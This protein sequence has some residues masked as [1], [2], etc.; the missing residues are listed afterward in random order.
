MFDNVQFSSKGETFL[1]KIFLLALLNILLSKYKFINSTSDFVWL[2]CGII[3]IWFGFWMHVT[4]KLYEKNLRK[5]ATTSK[6]AETPE[7]REE[8][9]RNKQV[10]LD[11]AFRGIEID[12]R[13]S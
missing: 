3:L 5:F 8:H 10:A 12:A 2:N 6:S 7:S 9:M 4:I 13:C 1:L 11:A